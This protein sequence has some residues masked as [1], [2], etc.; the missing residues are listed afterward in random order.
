[1][2]WHPEK[3]NAL[4]A[5]LASHEMPSASDIGKEFGCSRNAIIAACLRNGIKLPRSSG[6]GGKKQSPRN[7]VPRAKRKRPFTPRFTL[8][9]DNR[10]LRCVPVEPLHLSLLELERDSCRYP[11]GGD[12]DE[13]TTFCG[14]PKHG[15]GSYC[16]AHWQLTSKMRPKLSQSDDEIERRRRRMQH[17]RAA[18]E[19]TQAA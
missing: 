19:K 6:G 2:D 4:R 10:E 16:L 12:D 1:M 3:I 17:V 5:Y 14:H 11:Y 13:P 18:F 7:Y 15:D 8:E 9:P